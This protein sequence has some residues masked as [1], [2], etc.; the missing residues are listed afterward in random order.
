MLLVVVLKDRQKQL[1][2]VLPV[3]CSKLILSFVLL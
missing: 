3:L 1:S 2:W